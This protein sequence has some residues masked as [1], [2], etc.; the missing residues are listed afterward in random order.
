MNVIMVGANNPE[1]IR[2]IRD[3]D[4]DLFK[5]AGF[6]DNDKSIGGKF[7][8]YPVFG[9]TDQLYRFVVDHQFVNLITGSTASR[10]RVT[11]EIID[12]GGSFAN[13][14]HPSID[15]DIYNMIRFGSGIYI[16]DHVIIQAGVDIQDHVSIHTGSIIAHECIIGAH[17]FIAH[18]AC[19]SGKVEIGDGVFVGANATILPRLKIGKWATIGAG[20]VVTKDVNEYSVVVGNPARVIR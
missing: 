3:Q 8:R 20:A 16:Q 5:V 2:L 19:L 4:D 6:L 11:K 1:V 13:F 17:S 7:Y 14:I 9:G 10:Y 12:A 15:T 18:G